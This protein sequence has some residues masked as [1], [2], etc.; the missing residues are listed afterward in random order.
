MHICSCLDWYVFFFAPVCPFT[1]A[2]HEP[3]ATPPPARHRQLAPCAAALDTRHSHALTPVIRARPQSR[4]APTHPRPA[5]RL[6][7]P[8]HRAGRHQAQAPH[9]SRERG[10]GLKLLGFPVPWGPGPR[11]HALRSC[12][13]SGRALLFHRKTVVELEETP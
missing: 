5:D 2:Q 10:P 11:H 12:L 1:A 3:N 7:D 6:R 4:A 8:F 9:A 13:L